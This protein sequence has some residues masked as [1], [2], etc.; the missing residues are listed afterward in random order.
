[1]AGLWE[2]VPASPCS[3][4]SDDLLSANH[5]A[6]SS[7]RTSSMLPKRTLSE[8]PSLN[9]GAQPWKRTR[10]Q[11]STDTNS[12]SGSGSIE[13]VEA[14]STVHSDFVAR[15]NSSATEE[16]R[17]ALLLRLAAIKSRKKDLNHRPPNP[18][19][20]SDDDVIFVEENSI[21]A[22]HTAS[23]SDVKA[24][25]SA[26]IPS[27]Q[28]KGRNVRRT[29]RKKSAKTKPPTYSLQDSVI[30]VDDDTSTNSSAP[31][32]MSKVSPAKK[33]LATKKPAS[34]LPTRTS[35]RVRR[36]RTLD[37]SARE[38]NGE[39]KTPTPT[40]M[41]KCKRF[42]FCKKLT[43]SMLKNPAASPFV[44]P[45]N[46]LWPPEA[47]PRYFEVIKT[48]MDLRTVKRNL[49]TSVYIFPLKDSMLP[50]HFDVEKYADDMRLIF[51][52]AM[53]YNRVG[54]MLY[55]S[56]KHLM[57]DFDRT[58][59]EE[60]PSTPSAEE[61]A[62]SL[63][64]KRNSGGR[65]RKGRLQNQT[66]PS[67]NSERSG[68][69]SISDGPLLPSISPAT[70]RTPR[71]RSSCPPK[72][73]KN[74]SETSELFPSTLEEMSERLTYLR[75]SR[76]AV[77]ARTPLPQGSG[78]LSRAAL[79]YNIAISLS[80]KRRCAAAISQ[81]K[82]PSERMEVL[83]DM[84]RSA[85][86]PGEDDDD[87]ELDYDKLNNVTWRNLE[88]FLEQFVPGF[89]TIRHSTLGREFSS[90]EQVD[91]EVEDIQNRMKK[92]AEKTD[93]GDN[94]IEMHKPKKS[95]SFFD[96]DVVDEDSSSDSGSDSDDSDSSDSGSEAE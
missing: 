8:E 9:D 62:Q 33:S 43:N 49:E 29:T 56:A 82:V 74:D 95:S 28:P 21:I 50:Y 17:Q 39:N 54:D 66:Q 64:K 67:E 76:S 77:L 69:L 23:P 81:G 35:S 84:V 42:Q 2:G 87:F 71:R 37:I 36:P 5:R 92:L 24:G 3:A 79:L 86:T 83:L 20:P 93:A 75:N 51:R 73:K 38:P 68:S 40:C 80:Q 27:R 47:I 7:S 96:G 41:S 85:V 91:E 90:V 58:I 46:E 13:F 57:D 16:R 26:S 52:N 31:R 70:A 25:P 15:L 34:M 45:V 44:A 72:T 55:N 78:Y 61:I 19:Q 12:A 89:K 30:V 65:S 4:A 14:S 10:I 63:L 88:A 6:T 22:P 53:I 18:S 59:H 11:N 32:A 48:P 60:L 94:D 1:M